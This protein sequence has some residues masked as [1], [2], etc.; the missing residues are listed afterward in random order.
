MPTY[1]QRSHWCRLLG[2]AILNGMRREK[3]A[4]RCKGLYIQTAQ[5]RGELML[6]QNI[7]TPDQV[8]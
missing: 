5:E 2:L 7:Q 4:M 1:A 3:I 6:C 8:M